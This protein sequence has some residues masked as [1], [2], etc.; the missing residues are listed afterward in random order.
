MPKPVL[1]LYMSRGGHTA[2]V[3]RR[4]CESIDAAG[5]RGEMMSLLEADKEG[6]DWP[7]YGVV[8]L[9]AP[10]LYGTYDQSVFEF[11]AK[12]RAQLEARPSSFFNVSV[13]ART[14]EKATVGGNRYMQ[15]FLELSP[16]KPRDLK[17][18]AGKVDY[19]SWRWHERVM[20]QLIMK[21]T[22]GP[23]DRTAVIDY[24]DWDDVAAYGRHLLTLA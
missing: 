16:W 21:Y 14:P 6:V 17:V 15:K 24:T 5:S 2:R 12:Y 20:I 19:P 8:A 11:I 13:V 22:H 3:A 18:I 4:I 9:G 10:V 1:V 23:T 7:R